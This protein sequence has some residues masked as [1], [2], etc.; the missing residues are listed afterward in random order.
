MAIEGTFTIG[1]TKDLPRKQHPSW[2]VPFPFSHPTGALHVYLHLTIPDMVNNMF[3]NKWGL[4]V[5]RYEHNQDYLWP[6][7]CIR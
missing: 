2:F 3:Y 1:G 5:N 7:K 4:A 6:M